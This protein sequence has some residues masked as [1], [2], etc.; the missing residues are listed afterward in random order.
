MKYGFTTESYS[1]ERELECRELALELIK[2]AVNVRLIK[3]CKGID[4]GTDNVL[5]F[6]AKVVELTADLESDI[7]YYRGAVA[8]KKAKTE[9]KAEAM[10]VQDAPVEAV[11]V[12]APPVFIDDNGE[13]I[14]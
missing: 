14:N 5:D 8:K 4:M 9:A 13:A 3:A 11:N 10:Q 6:S 7:E 12:Q 2:E 1:D